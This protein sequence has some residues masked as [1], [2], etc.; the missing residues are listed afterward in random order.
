MTR[1]MLALAA[2]V[3]CLGAAP[4]LSGN[5]IQQSTIVFKVTKTPVFLGPTPQCPVFRSEFQLSSTDGAVLGSGK[6]CFQSFDF[7][8]DPPPC[9]DSAVLTAAFELPGGTIEGAGS[10]IEVYNPDGSV[11]QTGG[12]VVTRA[13]GIY[14]GLGGTISWS[15]QIVFDPNGVPHPDLTF[16]IHL[17]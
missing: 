1:L 17:A 8:C 9:H 4:A 3:L 5:P 6:F 10:F 13:T 12:A 7:S 11:T 15:G 2:A 16:T 14:L